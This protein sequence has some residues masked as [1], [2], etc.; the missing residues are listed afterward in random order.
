MI[1]SAPFRKVEEGFAWFETFA[2]LERSGRFSERN[3]KLD[4][5]LELSELAGRPDRSCRT[6]HLAGSKGKGSTAILLASAL[7][8]AGHPTGI[9]TS[10]HVQ[11]YRE[12]IARP[13]GFL[14]DGIL[15][16]AMNRVRTVMEKRNAPDDPP[17]T[18]ELLT[19]CAF[20]AFKAAGCT[21]V[22]LETG[23]GGRL[24]S[25]NIVTPEL[26][27]FTP[28]ELEHTDVLGSTLPAIAKEKA[29]IIKPGV[30]VCS[31]F[32]K[33]EVYE[34]FRHRAEEVG[35]PMHLLSE[36]LSDLSVTTGIDGTSVSAGFR[37]GDTLECGLSMYGRHQAENACLAFLCLKILT[38][39]GRPDLVSPR[40]ITEGFSRAKLPGRFEIIEKSPPLVL[41]TAHTPASV[42][43][44]V[45]TL[46][47]ITTEPGVLLFGAVSG[48]DIPGMANIL[49]PAFKHIVVS[50]PGIFK[51]NNP[52]EAAEIFR[53]VHSDVILEMEPGEA[54]RKA[55]GLAG[56]GVPILVTGSFYMA[57]EIRK[58]L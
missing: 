6:I 56:P 49:A 24:D 11:D 1:P 8:A 34:V 10:P 4:R 3:Y 27:V 32:Q 41:D 51:K 42:E 17:T 46:R 2:N 29:G 9:Y 39:A 40:A 25:T 7:Q 45:G 13:G 37:S 28:L 47:E 19:L 36:E 55:R 57:A 31:G 21:W 58:I 20:L 22:V 44:A 15:L 5:M 12:R 18:F 53:A 52:A 26:S 30:P 38:D 43:R 54:L 48:K 50:R 14:E 23:L 16:E 35:A 33:P